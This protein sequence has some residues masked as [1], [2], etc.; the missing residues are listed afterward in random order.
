MKGLEPKSSGVGI[1]RSANNCPSMPHGTLLQYYKCKLGSLNTWYVSVFYL[2]TANG[3]VAACS[4][5]AI[6]VQ[7]TPKVR[8]I[9]V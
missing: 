4:L 6:P 7:I 5:E 8:K 9:T 3:L 2:N 1:N